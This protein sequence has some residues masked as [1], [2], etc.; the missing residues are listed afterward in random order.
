[1][2]QLL[3][4]Y[5]SALISMLLLDAVWLGTMMSRFYKPR[6]SHLLA[7][8]ASYAP[9]VIFYLLYAVAVLFLVVQPA[10]KNTTSLFQVFLYGAL[11]GLASYG[12]YD[13][14]NQATLKGW[15]TSLTVVDLLWGAFIT[16]MVSV[17][18]VAITRWF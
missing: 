18:A 13:F 6:M 11:L 7:E 17:I 5:F 8:K 12:A 3:L 14:T 1:M 4:P 2:K 15:T 9:V 16:G 10:L